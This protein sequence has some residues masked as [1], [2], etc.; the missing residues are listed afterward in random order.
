VNDL[1]VYAAK[2]L[3]KEELFAS[4]HRA[5]QGC[6]PALILRMI[7]K[8]LGKN[9]IVAN[10]TGC[11]EIISSSYPQTAWD[12]PW[13]HVAFENSS[14]VA[15]GIESAL[16]VLRRKGRLPFDGDVT[17]MAVAGDG[18]SSD[19]GLQAISGALERGHKMIV[20]CYDNE[21]YMNTGVQRSSSTPLWASTTTS[22]AG[23]VSPGQKT[24]KKPL[25]EICAAHKIPYA[26]TMSPG[27]PFDLIQKVEKAKAAP[28]P[29]FLHVLGPCPT[30]WRCGTDI[31]IR[32]SRQAVQ[33]G[34]YPLFEIENGKLRV[35]YKPPFLKPIKDY[36]SVQGRFRHIS[37]DDLALLEE[38]FHREYELLLAREGA[39]A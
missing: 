19:I 11:M 35:T 15:S 32:L 12:I 3:P 36:V 14:A 10:S 7:L 30:G 31:G 27:Y 39:E 17:I 16:R 38:R 5:C 26:A 33:C 9:T 28:G 8:V 1:N 34:M 21:A 20:L 25:V 4:G 18:G 24:W 22:P 37:D 6:V 2:L 23:K 13:I 29:A